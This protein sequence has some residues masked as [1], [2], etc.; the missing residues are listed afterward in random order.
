M[1]AKRDRLRAGIGLSRYIY[2]L[3]F[4]LVVA[5]VVMLGLD[6]DRE[7][8][9]T[10]YQRMSSTLLS[11]VRFQSEKLLQA[12]T[13]L[14]ND[15]LF[16]SRTPPLQGIAR[17]AGNGGFDPV[18]K[19]DYAVWARRLQEIFTAFLETRPEYFQASYIGLADHGRELVRVERLQGKV[20]VVPETGLQQKSSRDYFK[21]SLK[22]GEGQ[23][24]LSEFSLSQGH[25]S[26]EM[27]LTPILRAVTPIYDSAGRVFGL[28]V[29]N[30]DAGPL[31]KQLASRSPGGDVAYA[32]DE[33][34]RYLVHPEPGRAFA[35]EM[36]DAHRLQSD[37]PGMADMLKHPDPN[38]DATHIGRYRLARAFYYV[39]TQAIRFDPN[40]PDRFVL[41]VYATPESSLTREING[42]RL[43]VIV[44]AI[45]ALVLLLP[46]VALLIRIIMQ[47]LSQL[48]L[49][50][51]AI[52]R[53]EYDAALPAIQSGE[54]GM[55]VRGFEHMRDQ[56]AQR[57]EVLKRHNAA[58]SEQVS[59]GSFDLRLA[60][61]V[62]E[63]TSE[64]VMVTDCK[65][66]IISVN[67]AFTEIVGYS[68]QEAIGNT[69]RLFR[70]DH[71]DAAF[72]QEIWNRLLSVGHWQGEIW[73]RRKGGEV[74]LEWLTINR[75]LGDTPDDDH[76]IAVFT[77]VTEQRRK[78]ERIHH[79]AFHDPLTGLPNRTLVQDRLQHAIDVARR[80]HSRT[81]VMLIDLDRF[82]A[83]NDGLGH[84][85]G[86]MLLKRIAERLTA[87][88]RQTDTVARM[89]GDEFLVILES[90]VEPEIYAGVAENII[91]MISLPVDIQG[92]TIQVGASV[93]IAFY[94]DDG[95][96]V[97]A[98]IKHADVAMYAA[99][100][101]GKGGFRFFR[102]EMT[103][104]ATQYLH[105]EMELRQAIVNSELELHYQ[106]KVLLRSG[107]MDG[108]EAL[109]RW[110]HPRRG[111]VSPA[112][113]IPVAEESGLILELGDWVLM[114]ACRQAALWQGRMGVI[115]VNV[116]ARQFDKVDLV[117]R[118]RELTGRHGIAPSSIQLE[119]TESTVMTNPDHVIELLKRVRELGITVAVDDFG[120]G[121]SSLSYLR[122][123]P[124]DI[125]KIDR[126]FITNA[127]VNEEDTQI[128]RT[129][130][131]LGQALK[132]AVVA[133][134]V[135][136]RAQA[137][138]L[139]A[140]GC[141]MGQGYLY[142]SPQSAADLEGWFDKYQAGH[143]EPEQNSA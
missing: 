93:G 97:A 31:L 121:Y 22:L 74:F 65:A 141:D 4:G 69:P 73:N 19:N 43:E 131:A 79:L 110:R 85:V 76:F 105:L 5:G 37:A 13:S 124:I 63:N 103:E 98:L 49:A 117:E 86:D 27:P 91:R 55:L 41:L 30:M 114:E 132:M 89:G 137:E 101:D 80:K 116:S 115:A 140:M 52:S 45:L 108:V 96:D 24:L 48:S 83:V 109:V 38:S 3:V 57:E 67:P 82:K 126:S 143:S 62:V 26:N 75:V 50:A 33:Q 1:N 39:A 128:A 61:N 77:D 2:L 28:V 99:K 138:L 6:S 136:T 118:I 106:P 11:D 78:D 92:S 47:P 125:L 56:V 102:P 72:Y 100:A 123:L 29:V 129:V 10:V 14:R 119:L 81:G 16:L 113:F 135:E 17:A 7:H 20:V 122:R 53:G 12:T 94:P 44:G 25:G 64:G 40:R 34:G 84:D 104:R 51:A 60:G 112:D 120:T 15:T 21:A 46:A 107:R 134:G 58:L 32:V 66:R 23:V 133:E 35:Y 127:G 142:A 87:E 90:G 88:L 36:G 95:G 111:L 68:A 8:R 42:Y 59:K 54:V 9:A 70:S 71:H 130:V 18:D 139:L